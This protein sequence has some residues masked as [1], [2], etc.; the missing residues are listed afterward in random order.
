MHASHIHNRYGVIG[1]CVYSKKRLRQCLKQLSTR[2]L[3]LFSL[4]CKFMSHFTFFISILS[5]CS[6]RLFVVQQK[7]E[8]RI[9]LRVKYNNKKNKTKI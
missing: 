5:I 7:W 8:F 4:P 6:T 2:Q 9:I 1:I 3:Q